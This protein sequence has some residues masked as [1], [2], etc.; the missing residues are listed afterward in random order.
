[1]S[2]QWYYSADG[3][4]QEGPVEQGLLEGMLARGDLPATALVWREGMAQWAPAQHVSDL[5]WE[6]PATPPPLP[7]VHHPPALPAAPPR[8]ALERVEIR[9]RTRRNAIL[10]MLGSV[11]FTAGGIWLM[12]DGEGTVDGLVGAA[13]VLFFGGG[14]LYALPRLLR[15]PVSLVLEPDALV[16]VTLYG[17]ARVP[18]RDVERVGVAS[19]MGQRLL[20]MRLKTYDG[21][22]NGMSAE[23]AGTI[24]RALP[25]V[26]VAGTVLGKLDPGAALGLWSRF[27]G[28][29]DPASAV[30]AM[31]KVGDLAGMLLWCRNT[32]GYDILFGWADT[33]RPMP[34]L[35]ALLERYRSAAG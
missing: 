23:L 20:G 35:A 12:V 33:D 31:G 21:Y 13:C 30:A 24:T 8:S 15:R 18:W 10:L 7:A 4:R 3:T 27:Q 19:W 25:Y 16:Q 6:R 5:I 17:S 34:E 1:V 29:A 22:L 32:F 26:R 11:L 2:S 9:P 14:G 28:H